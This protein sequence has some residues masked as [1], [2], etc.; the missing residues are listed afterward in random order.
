[1]V[2]AINKGAEVG[3]SLGPPSSASKPSKCG[4]NAPNAARKPRPRP[5]STSFFP[6]SS[7]PSTDCGRDL[8]FSSGSSRGLAKG[9]CH[10]GQYSPS[11]RESPRGRAIGSTGP[12]CGSAAFSVR[13]V[14]AARRAGL[15]FAAL[16]FRTA[17]T[18]PTMGAG[19][20]QCRRSDGGVG[21]SAIWRAERRSNCRAS[22]GWRWRWTAI[23]SPCRGPSLTSTTRLATRPNR[24]RL[25]RRRGRPPG[26][27]AEIEELARPVGNHRR[28]HPGDGRFANDEK[29]RRCKGRARSAH[30]QRA[31]R[32]LARQGP[33]PARGGPTAAIRRGRPRAGQPYAGRHASSNSGIN[34]CDTTTRSRPRTRLIWTESGPTSNTAWAS[35]RDAAGN[36]PGPAEKNRVRR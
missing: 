33:G 34:W 6:A 19:A 26:R 28:L 24:F 29:Q 25:M 5:R 2:F 8:R 7:G 35:C 12:C 18:G 36:R 27:L 3:Y 1:M 17:T 22:C 32:G 30:V 4:S 20:G 23:R 13:R 9:L 10:A 31:G 15:P 16:E 11:N 21:A 14:S